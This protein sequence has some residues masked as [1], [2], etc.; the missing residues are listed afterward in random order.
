[1][2]IQAALRMVS[3]G[4]DSVQADFTYSLHKAER[5]IDG[6]SAAGENGANKTDRSGY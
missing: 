2:V 5:E 1:M 3:G 4:N 6:M